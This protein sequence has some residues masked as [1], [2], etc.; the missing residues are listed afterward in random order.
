MFGQ[1][2]V[3]VFTFRANAF[4]KF[5]IYLPVLII[6]LFVSIYSIFKIDS[7]TYSEIT[8]FLFFNSIHSIWSIGV[9]FFLKESIKVHRFN[10]MTLLG[11]LIKF[12]ILYSIII[13]PFINSEISNSIFAVVPFIFVTKWFGDRHNIMQTTGISNVLLAQFVA[14]I[15]NNN[16]KVQLQK[17]RKYEKLF[18]Q[19]LVLGVLVAPSYTYFIL[20][21]HINQHWFSIEIGLSLIFLG[22]L[23][24][25]WFSFKISRIMKNFNKFWIDVRLILHVFQCF[26]FLPYFIIRAIHGTEY[27]L[28]NAKMIKRSRQEKK[29]FMILMLLIL[30][31][32]FV[33]LY[34]GR[35][36]N[37]PLNQFGKLTY[38]HLFLTCYATAGYLH[39]F[40]DEA[41]FTMKDL[42]VREN[43]GPLLR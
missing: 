6:A 21:P 40:I 25:L 15:E 28:I 16:L 23:G 43:I 41:M 42:R 20:F 13:L 31:L 34:Y 27:M 8:N 5:Q 37:I 7:Q 14:E 24:Q 39:F 33:L 35:Y 4:D 22:L 12:L 26:S 11:I 2:N 36:V 1:L 18:I 38:G 32:I 10:W 29:Y 9:F 17:L 3:Q 30:A 19:I